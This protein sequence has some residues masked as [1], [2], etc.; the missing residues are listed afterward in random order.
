M[1]IC[2]RPWRLEDVEDLVTLCNSVGRSFLSDRL[3]NPYTIKD[4]E[5]WL[6][7]VSKDE[8][9]SGIF[10]A[11]VI[12]KQVIGSISVEKKDDVFRI[13]GE[14][15]YMLLCDYWNKGIMTNAVKQMC[16]T[17][18]NNLSLERIT[19]NVYQPN[20]ASIQVLKKNGF[21]HEGTLKRAVIKNGVIYD[22]CFFGLTKKNCNHSL[23]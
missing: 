18:F 3:P 4:A 9:V 7:R 13:D 10:R 1:T 14:I 6:H 16:V 17:A 12:D 22:L 8:A 2:L 20:V 19:A 21:V 5:E 23:K 15:S 11:I